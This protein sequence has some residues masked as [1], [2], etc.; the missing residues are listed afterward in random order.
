MSQSLTHKLKWVLFFIFDFGSCFICL[1]AKVLIISLPIFSA[2]F[3]HLWTRCEAKF[4]TYYFYVILL[5]RIKE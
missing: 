2:F 5:L 4:L 1:F 3:M